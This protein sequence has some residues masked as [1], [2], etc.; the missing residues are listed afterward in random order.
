[1]RQHICL[2]IVFQ[3]LSQCKSIAGADPAESQSVPVCESS[4]SGSC[5]V[6]PARSV[7]D[8]Q[9]AAPATPVEDVHASTS[10]NRTPT[11][12]EN[13]RQ[14]MAETRQQVKKDSFNMSLLWNLCDLK[15][16]ES[17]L[18][19]GSPQAFQSVNKASQ[20]L[21]SFV[22]TVQMTQMLARSSAMHSNTGKE[23]SDTSVTTLDD[24]D[25]DVQELPFWRYFQYASVASQRLLMLSDGLKSKFQV[26]VKFLGDVLKNSTYCQNLT[27]QHALVSH[28]PHSASKA[29][30]AGYADFILMQKLVYDSNPSPIEKKELSKHWEAS[31]ALPHPLTWP[32][33]E[34]LHMQLPGIRA[35]PFW[36]CKDLPA[37]TCAW[38]QNLEQ[39]TAVIEDELNAFLSAPESPLDRGMDTYSVNI[40]IAWR[41]LRCRR[42][43][44]NTGWPRWASLA[45]SVNGNWDATLCSGPFQKTCKLLQ[46]RKE[47]DASRFN[48]T[49]EGS[50][51]HLV[52]NVSKP[53]LMVHLYRLSPGTRL[54]PHFGTHGRLVISLGLTGTEG[55]AT[56]ETCEGGNCTAL[57]RVG[58]EEQRWQHGRAHIFDDAF[59]HEVIHPCEAAP[60]FVL[61]ASILHPDVTASE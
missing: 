51:A 39:N 12:L 40:H 31:Q 38:V 18:L 2:W 57:L 36:K 41:L 44:T 47:L 56:S 60:R 20:C 14:Q 34:Q 53:V 16:R 46:N 32:S 3:I 4:D 19:E 21:Q 7:S 33:E 28:I 23:Q 49:W 59:E 55:E 54:R 42:S 10:E 17:R 61:A 45:L 58:G 8:Q 35:V 11:A 15:F 48:F 22:S 1:M 30:A 26:G 24:D 25:D 50:G 43:Q 27:T 29:C 5:K 6:D 13:I 52:G 9:A 37:T